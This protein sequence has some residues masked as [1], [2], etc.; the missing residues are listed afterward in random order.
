MK[1]GVLEYKEEKFIND[2]MARLPGSE[3]VKFGVTDA[4]LEKVYDV[5]IDRLS[6][7]IEFF[8]PIIKMYSLQGTYVINNPFTSG[9]DDKCLQNQICERLG[10]PIPKTVLIPPVYK[11]R[12]YAD[13][14]N[15]IDW[16]KFRNFPLILKPY[17]GYAWDDVYT[18]RSPEEIGNLL[19]TIGGRKVFIAQECLNYDTYLRCFCINKKDVLFIEYDPTKRAYL[20]SELR[21]IDSLKPQLTEWMIKLNDAL[22][23]DINT[24]EWTVK[25]G[26]AIM[27]DAFNE[28]PEVLPQSIPHE[29]YRWIV[30]KFVECVNDKFGRKNKMI[31][32]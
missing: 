8:K 21:H 1:I 15:D 7:Q 30:D 23:Y 22:D 4:P 32:G 2:V 24:V 28:V 27:I 12:D 13:L 18:V 5:L 6:F 26:N 9:C 16:S 20:E 3:F 31:F 17:D 14:I 11:E 25:D 19:S 29:Y 10:I